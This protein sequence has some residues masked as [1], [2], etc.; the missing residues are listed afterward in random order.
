MPTNTHRA[1]KVHTI[2]AAALC[3]LAA[4]RAGASV[5]F[6]DFQSGA[7]AEWSNTTTTTHDAFTTFLGRFNNQ[8][9]T[10]TV[11]T[12]P[13]ASYL[14]T[15][16]FYAIDRWRGPDGG[17]N[18]LTIAAAGA[19]IFSHTFNNEGPQ[20]SYPFAPDSGPAQ[21]GFNAGRDDAI[22]RAVT[23]TFTATAPATHITFTASGL[24]GAISQA[25]W[26]VDNVDVT[27]TH[28]ADIPAP[29]PG[30]VFA[31]AISLISLRRRRIACEVAA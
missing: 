4:P 8:S 15:F 1:L 30:A 29:G 24:I 17:E 27:R 23:A 13:G 10:L 6:T 11:T 22:Y 12:D 20:Q 9:V 19:D 25:S 21:L 2:A 3:A 16:D 14:L 18:R 7:G 28:A 31:I 5:Y 26:G